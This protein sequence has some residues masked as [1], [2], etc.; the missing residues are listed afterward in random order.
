MGCYEFANKG[1]LNI[2]IVSWLVTVLNLNELVK[3]LQFDMCKKEMIKYLDG[4]IFLNMKDFTSN[5]SKE[6]MKITF[7]FTTFK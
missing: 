4:I 2:H 3:K 7:L 1:S 5:D 6:K